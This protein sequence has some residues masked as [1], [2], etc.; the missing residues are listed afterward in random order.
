[1]RRRGFLLTGL[2]AA[3][4]LPAGG[5]FAQ[6]TAREVV[7]SPILTIESDRFFNQSAYGQRLLD[8]I[9]EEGRALAAENRRFEAELTAEEQR[10][11]EIRSET[12]P[13]EF[14]AMADA[15]DARVEELRR[16]Q[17]AK[18]RELS[19]RD[20]TARRTFFSQAQPVLADI[21]REAGAALI[22]ERGNVLLSANAIDITELA[23]RRLDAAIGDG[24]ELEM[25]AP[26][27]S[28]EGG[29]A[30]EG[31]P[32]PEAP[33]AEVPAP[34]PGSGTAPLF[35]MGEGDPTPVE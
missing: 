15:F 28:E 1:M 29:A 26:G 34:E 6:D 35:D 20:E 24:A 12:D 11:T 27:A 2:A 21:L 19:N 31:A 13:V 25:P 18:A 3:A 10:L 17:D 14:R 22:L 4:L 9:E 5:V 30:P 33:E 32:A 8:Q 16:Q 7:R 23:I